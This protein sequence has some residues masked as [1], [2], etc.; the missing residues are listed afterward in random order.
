M[1]II[2]SN[3]PENLEVDEKLSDTVKEAVEKVGQLYALDNAEVSITL[4]DNE[5]IHEINREYRKVDRRRGVGGEEDRL[6]VLLPAVLPRRQ[7]LQL[8]QGGGEM[9]RIRRVAGSRKGPPLRLQGKG[10]MVQQAQAALRQPGAPLKAHLPVGAPQGQMIH[11]YSLL[12]VLSGAAG[13]S[14][15]T[16][17]Q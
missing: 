4:T 8:L 14:A 7:P 17:E 9:A 11:V 16:I 15:L 10:H 2:L 13:S 1:E 6:Q 5:H 12:P 3:L